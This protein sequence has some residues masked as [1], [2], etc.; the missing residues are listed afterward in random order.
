[1]DE[2]G[3]S[4]MEIREN[5]DL[6]EGES[7][8]EGEAVRENQRDWEMQKNGLGVG[9]GKQD[10][11]LTLI[12]ILKKTLIYMCVYHLS[13]LILFSKLKPSQIE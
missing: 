7:K 11:K 2:D 9:V 1:M 4:K 5:E 6:D 12:Y 13:S 3:Q 10:N 8:M